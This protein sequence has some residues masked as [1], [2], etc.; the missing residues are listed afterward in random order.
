MSESKPVG[1]PTEPVPHET[2]EEI[3]DWISNGKTLRDFCRQ[4]GKPAFRTVYD[5][6]AKDKEFAARFA[7]ARQT[8]AEVI[9]CEIL[10]IIDTDPE[11]IGAEDAK[12]IDPGS[13]NT[14]RNRAEM[15]L[16][17]LAKWFPQ[18]YGDRTTIAGDAEY[19]IIQ[20]S[21]AERTA[22]IQNLLTT[23]MVRKENDETEDGNGS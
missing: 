19:P 1:R 6:L 23:A 13:V 21:E 5:W 11:R 9:A 10:E 16:K 14:L 12:R 2:S 18:K 7:H 8:G 4:N 17:L 3:I 20:L 15:R 22:K